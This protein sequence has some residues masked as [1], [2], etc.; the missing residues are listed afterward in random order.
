M[1][2]HNESKQ[3]NVKEM[4]KFWLTWT[5]KDKKYAIEIWHYSAKEAE[6]TI[7]KKHNP[8]AIL[9]KDKTENRLC[10]KQYN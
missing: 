6:E 9:Y 3:L 10:K 1:S 4:K 7:L 2:Y 8:K 5:V